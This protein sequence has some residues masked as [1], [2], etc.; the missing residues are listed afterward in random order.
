MTKKFDHLRNLTANI[1]PNQESLASVRP[2][3]A[4]ILTAE[5]TKRLHDAEARAASLE[6]QLKERQPSGGAIDL[7]LDILYEE[8]GRKRNLDANEYELLK[9][10]LS[11]NKLITPIIVRKRE[12]GGYEI[13]SGHNRTQVFRELGKETIPAIVADIDVKNANKDAFFANL[14]HSSL[15]DYEKYL[16]LERM[17]ADA[18]S[19]TQEALSKQ[20]GIHSSHLSML[21]SYRRLPKQVHSLLDNRPS[22]IGS[23]AAS[24]LAGALKDTKPELIVKAVEL[25]AANEIDQSKARDWI[26]KA[27]AA[28]A[29]TNEKKQTAKPI[30]IKK[31][32]APFCNMRR[33]QKVIRLEFATLDE[34]EQIEEMVHE[35]LKSTASSN[36]S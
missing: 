33:T 13:I 24:D 35:F 2:K 27:V 12:A 28:D 14:I 1:T 7:D 4:P 5:A 11:Q 9:N 26:R 30:V 16:G 36:K 19:L 32:R 15:P 22:L 17:L 18:P 6:L 3:T 23:R 21:M 29:K 8:P 34:A 25:I 20:I 10:N 31:G